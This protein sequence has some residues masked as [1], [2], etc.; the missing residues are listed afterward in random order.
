MPPKLG[1]VAVVGRHQSNV[2]PV[3]VAAL[4]CHGAN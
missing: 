2:D 1:F 4:I 3:A